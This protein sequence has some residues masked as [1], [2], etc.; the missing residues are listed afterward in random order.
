ML[1]HQRAV[2][3]IAAIAAMV[4]PVAASANAASTPSYAGRW[5][6]ADNKPQFSTK[7]RFYKTLDVA[8]CG[9]DV[10]GVSVNDSGICGPVL[11][12]F[13]SASLARE[14]QARG[15]GRWGTAKK[16][17]LFSSWS[18]SDVPGGR[19]MIIYLGDGYNFG[20]RSGNMPKYSAQYRPTGRASC[21]AR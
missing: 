14:E 13:R 12:R 16:K 10:C 21:R 19:R 2:L 18:D 11:F 15:H 6:V 9:S 5:T 20:E 1:F 8:P 4:G 3:S 7:G 17:L